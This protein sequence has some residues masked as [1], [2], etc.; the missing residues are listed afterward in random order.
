MPI[1]RAAVLLIATLLPFAIG[2]KKSEPPKPGAWVTCTCPYLTDYDDVAK[3]SLE[4]C[5]PQGG[6][7]EKAAFECASKL[8]H[9]PAEACTCGEPKGPC[10]TASPCK[11][12]EYK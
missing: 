11:S 8:T 10:D 4:V 5:V 12:N 1:S 3:H 6:K 2:C 9:G 7:P